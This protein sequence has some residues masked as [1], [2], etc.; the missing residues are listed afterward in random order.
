MNEHKLEISP[1]DE[2]MRRTACKILD[3][4][5]K[6]DSR[7][8]KRAFR[9]MAKKFHPDKNPS[10]A[11]AKKKFRLV[12]C[13]YELLAENKPSLELL[14]ESTSGATSPENEKY[15]LDNSWGLF[16]WWRDKFFR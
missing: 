5:E 7:Q 4:S 8:L 13:A 6:A 15:H 1:F 2:T 12:K 16:L 10:D 11:G 3:V 14:Q 9:R